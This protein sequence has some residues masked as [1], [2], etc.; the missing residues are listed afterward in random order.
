MEWS[1]KKWGDKTWSNKPWSDKTWSDK[2]W[3]DDQVRRGFFLGCIR[4]K[5]DIM[6]MMRLWSK[7]SLTLYDANRGRSGCGKSTT[8]GQRQLSINFVIDN[9]Y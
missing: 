9:I 1:D 7:K 3:S 6:M 2:T 5:Y 4:S 8:S